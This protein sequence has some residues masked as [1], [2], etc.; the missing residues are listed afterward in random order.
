M[1]FVS[2]YA[3]L[4]GP[5]GGFF[6]SGLK[7]SLDIKVSLILCRTFQ[8]WFQVMEESSIDSI[9]YFS[10]QSPSTF[11]SIIFYGL[12]QMVHSNQ[13]GSIAWKQMKSFS[14]CKDCRQNLIWQIW[15][16]LLKWLIWVGLWWN[17]NHWWIGIR[18]FLS[19]L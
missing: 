15:G 16:D 6:A 4:L 2:L 12:P 3:S 14:S 7:R 11:I 17:K 18:R 13:P 8:I 10:W 19:S 5:F 1:L 9:A